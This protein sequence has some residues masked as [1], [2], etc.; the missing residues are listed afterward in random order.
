MEH[1]ATSQEPNSQAEPDGNEDELVWGA[2]AIGK[3]I[4]RG[5]R[6]VFHLAGTG[7]FPWSALAVACVHAS[8]NCGD[9]GMKDP[10]AP[11]PDVATPGA[12]GSYRKRR[13]LPPNRRR[14]DRVREWAI[15]RYLSVGGHRDFAH[16]H[17]AAT[18]SASGDRENS[19]AQVRR[20]G[21]SRHS[22]RSSQSGRLKL[23]AKRGVH[24]NGT[25]VTSS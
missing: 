18:H 12:G 11:N 25:P 6:Q 7:R 13:I 24:R 16:V 1:V 2:I 10:Y 23:S 19:K 9:C 14:G 22:R 5:E 20:R 3:V 15:R 21:Q 17:F 4:N 8:R